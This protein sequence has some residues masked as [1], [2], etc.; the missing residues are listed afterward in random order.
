MEKIKIKRFLISTIRENKKLEDKKRV[1]LK[2][3]N[4]YLELP[5]FVRRQLR[6]I[7]CQKEINI[8]KLKKEIRNVF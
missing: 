4:R 5:N 1:I 2:K 8:I 3:H 6:E 7:D